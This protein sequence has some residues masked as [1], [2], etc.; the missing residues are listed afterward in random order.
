MITFPQ[1]GPA[2]SITEPN[3]LG[4]QE[5]K[6]TCELI[7]SYVDAL[8]ASTCCT[9]PDSVFNMLEDTTHLAFPSF[10]GVF[11]PTPLSCSSPFFL[12]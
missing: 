12:N 6:M 3:L 9:F 10:H 4:G 1:W 5:C 7:T 2:R 11:N 8:P